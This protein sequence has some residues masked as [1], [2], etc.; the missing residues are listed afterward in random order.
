M[1]STVTINPF[2]SVGSV[3]GA[4]RDHAPLRGK[5]DTKTEMSLLA[6][7]EQRPPWKAPSGQTKV[8]CPE[9]ADR[10]R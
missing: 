2:A 4:G 6:E 8:T 1:G 3:I 9:G 10:A 7:T 5:A